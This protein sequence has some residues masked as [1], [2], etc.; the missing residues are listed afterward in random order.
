M[1]VLGGSWACAPTARLNLRCPSSFN[2]TVLH[3]T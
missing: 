3:G 1:L 2:M